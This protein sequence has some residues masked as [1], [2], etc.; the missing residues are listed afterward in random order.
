VFLSCGAIIC[1]TIFYLTYCTNL[2]SIKQVNKAYDEQ[3]FIVNQALAANFFHS[4]EQQTVTL[5][6][7][8]R[9][10]NYYAVDDHNLLL[11]QGLQYL[12]KNRLNISH[13]CFHNELFTFPAQTALGAC[14]QL[15]NDTN[16][17][18]FL[19][20]D[21]VDE[22]SGYIILAP[23]TGF[24][25]GIPT[26]TQVAIFY[27]SAYLNDNWPGGIFPA[28]RRDLFTSYYVI[29]ENNQY[30]QQHHRQWIVR[31]RQTNSAIVKFN[32]LQPILLDSLVPQLVQNDRESLQLIAPVN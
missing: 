2:A 31:D 11:T 5:Y 4:L 23:V 30:Q 15:Y 24:Y 28:L 16:N 25:Q 17:N 8:H 32:S 20:Y 26:G 6:L 12:F 21:Q 3:R 19:Y 7:T 18:Y 22:Y 9:D 29:D 13:H 10:T 1:A 14:D 27:Y